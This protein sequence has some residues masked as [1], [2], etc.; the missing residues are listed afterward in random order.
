MAVGA[1]IQKGASTTLGLFL[2]VDAV[3]YGACGLGLRE[4]A[5]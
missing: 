4:E 1:C 5:T 2:V 3:P